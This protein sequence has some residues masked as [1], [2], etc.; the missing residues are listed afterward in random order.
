MACT[1]KGCFRDYGT[2]LSKSS[3]AEA[4]NE[5]IAEGILL[6]Q[7]QKSSVGRDLGSLYGIRIRELDWWRAKGKKKAKQ[8]GS[9]GVRLPDT[10][11][12]P[13]NS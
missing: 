11:H 7:R 10:S 2:G 3:V 13:K 1:E 12:K 5:A 6:R 4:V 9:A 8:K